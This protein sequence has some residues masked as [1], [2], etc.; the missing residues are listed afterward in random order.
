MHEIHNGNL[1]RKLCYINV[2]VLPKR[3]FAGLNGHTIVFSMY[4]PIACTKIPI[5]TKNLCP[6]FLRHLSDTEFSKLLGETKSSI[7]YQRE[8]HFSNNKEEKRKTKTT[9]QSDDD[10][11]RTTT[12]P[13]QD[14]KGKK[15]MWQKGRRRQKT[16]SGKRKR[17]KYIDCTTTVQILN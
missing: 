2:Y 13:L 9:V 5:R 6:A 4:T 3:N 17:S 8:S 10:L 14:E 15:K 12:C 16:R 7:Q 1:S 11:D